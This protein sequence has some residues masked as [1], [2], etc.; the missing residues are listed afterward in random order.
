MNISKS[1][2]GQLPTGEKVSLYTL[3]NNNLM[4]VGI[5]NYGGTIVSLQTPDRNNEV[6]D[7]VLGFGSVEEYLSDVYLSSSPYFGCTIGRYSNRIKAGKFQIDGVDINVSQNEGLNSL[8]G[9]IKGFDKHLWTVSD[10]GFINDDGVGIEMKLISPDGDQGYP[11]EL[12]VTMKIT[13]LV[14]NKLV[15]EYRAKS[16]KDTIVSLTNHSYFNLSGEGSG[17]ILGHQLTI[18]SDKV[19]ILDSELIPTGEISLVEGSSLDFTKSI[20]ISDAM[21]LDGNEK[22]TGGYAHT[23]IL[24]PVDHEK[25]IAAKLNDPVSGRTMEIYTDEPGILLYTGDGLDGSLTGKSGGRFEKWGGLCL[26]TQQ[27]P[28]APNHP[29]F[30]SG[31]LPAGKE[32]HSTTIYGFGIL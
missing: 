6:E 27:I 26:E 4:E 24:D 17:T 2:F 12:L 29:N 10:D 20:A 9:G 31:L 30:P 19:L 16:N 3:K 25:T 18:P 8:H 13:L 1:S 14:E 21:K 22:I 7:I 15:I 11:G 28:D 32:Y 5:S 23:Y